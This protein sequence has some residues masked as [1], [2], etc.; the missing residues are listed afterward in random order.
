M[1]ILLAACIVL[2]KTVYHSRIKYCSSGH[3][4]NILVP[5]PIMEIN[6]T[7]AVGMVCGEI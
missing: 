3:A 5:D 6:F 2:I 1:V 4:F 7:A